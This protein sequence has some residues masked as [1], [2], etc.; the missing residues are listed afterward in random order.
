MLGRLARWLRTLGYDTAFDDAIADEVLVRR[1]L[2]EGRHI[3]T[4][5]RRLFQEWRVGGGLVLVAERPLAQVREVVS[6]FALERPRR[7]FTRC[8]VCNGVV[9][10]VPA[11]TVRGE[12]P[13]RVR[14]REDRFARCTTCGRV[15]WEGSH[16]E[17]MRATLDRV[18]SEA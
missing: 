12:V 15:Y 16:T 3:L 9:E 8:R 17:R 13:S 4:R 18:F 2:E 6:A 7:L 5:D 11:E 1:S 10:P 14:A